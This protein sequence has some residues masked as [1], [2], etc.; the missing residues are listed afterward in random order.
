MLHMRLLAK[1]VPGVMGQER[2]ADMEKEWCL[3][4]SAQLAVEGT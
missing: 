4:R 1:L 3:A 2:M